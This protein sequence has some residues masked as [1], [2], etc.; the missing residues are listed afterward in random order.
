MRPYD[1]DVDEF[2]CDVDGDCEY[3]EKCLSLTKDK[4]CVPDSCQKDSDC[5]NLYS[6]SGEYENYTSE[7]CEA[8]IGAPEAPSTCFWTNDRYHVFH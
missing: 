8:P 1:L 5:P 6:S 2:G 3:N 4:H 7:G